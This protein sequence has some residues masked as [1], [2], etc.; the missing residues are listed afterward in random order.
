MDNINY[1]DIVVIALITLLGL[2]GLFRGLIKELFALIGLVAGV[3]FAAKYALNVGNF[4]SLNIIP[5]T[6]ESAITLL[7]FIVSLVSIWI[8]AYVLGIIVSNIFSASGLGIFD[9]IL[10]FLFGASKV[11][12]IFSFIVFAVSRMEVINSKLENFTSNSIMYPILLDAGSAIMKIDPINV[13]ENI[14]K[15][16]NEI[17]DTTQNTIKDNTIK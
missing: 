11:F 10:G 13:K 9:K 6:N 4:I 2:K 8:T 15:N 7:G 14:S 5:L 12:F 3:Y 17:I 16:I 1:F